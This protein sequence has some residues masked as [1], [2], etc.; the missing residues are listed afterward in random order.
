[1]PEPPHDMLGKILKIYQY[2]LISVSIVALSW[3]LIFRLNNFLFSQIE[4]L[5]LTN[6]IFLPAGLRL[7]SI[8]LFGFNAVVGLL[9]GN[10]IT[11]THLDLKSDYVFFISLISAINPYLAF[12]IS[13]SLL[14]VNITLVGLTTRQ[15]LLM[16]IIYAFVNSLSHNVYFYFTGIN[17]EFLINTIKMLIGDLIGSLLVIYI[18]S[19]SIKLSKKMMTSNL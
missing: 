15:L 4:E 14:K 17:Q 12:Q 1:M 5:S 8:L 18:F 19:M 6:W 16:C 7:I 13:K 9:I 3:I 10:L 2:H 11:I